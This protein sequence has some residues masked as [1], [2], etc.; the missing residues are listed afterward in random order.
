MP[1][2][3]SERLKFPAPGSFAHDNLQPPK[4]GFD[5][6]ARQ[7]PN[8]GAQNSGLENGVFGSVEPNPVPDEVLVDDLTFDFNPRRRFADGRDLKLKPAATVDKPAT[9]PAGSV[10]RVR[11]GSKLVNGGLG[12]EQ[13]VV[14]DMKDTAAISAKV[15]ERLGTFERAQKQTVDIPRNSRAHGH[16]MKPA[17]CRGCR[18]KAFD[19]HS[20]PPIMSTTP[21]G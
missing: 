6:R 8:A 20:P 7:N 15:F 2:K 1:P 12:E 17:A 21:I 10:R 3:Q 11:R 19:N 4:L 18:E 9:F 14:S 5:L 13:H 16:E